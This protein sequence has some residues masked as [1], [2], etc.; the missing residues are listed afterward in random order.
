MICPADKGQPLGEGKGVFLGD[1]DGERESQVGA[2]RLSLQRGAD[3]PAK[4]SC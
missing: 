1:G 4:A 2:T 3:C